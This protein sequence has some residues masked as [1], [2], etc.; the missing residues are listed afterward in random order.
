VR[1]DVAWAFIVRF[2]NGSAVPTPPG[3]TTFALTYGLGGLSA[4]PVQFSGILTVNGQGIPTTPLLELQPGERDV[5]I[6]TA[7]VPSDAT[8]T[9]T[10]TGFYTAGPLVGEPVQFGNGSGTRIRTASGA[11]PGAPTV[12][13]VPPA[14]A[15]PAPVPTPAGPVPGPTPAPGTPV[16]TV[17]PG[18]F[19]PAL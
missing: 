8:F 2:C 19:P 6:R 7:V 1:R 11:C 12:V 10:L 17:P 3:Q 14:P 9:V 13:S 4:G 16:K 5:R 18:T 15:P